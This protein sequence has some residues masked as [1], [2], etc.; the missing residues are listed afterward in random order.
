MKVR[1]MK[2]AVEF[3]RVDH[4]RLIVP[5]ARFLSFLPIKNQGSRQANS[6]W[7]VYQTW[8]QQDAVGSQTR[9][10]YGTLRSLDVWHVFSL[11]SAPVSVSDRLWRR[12]ALTAQLLPTFLQCFPLR[13]FLLS[14]SRV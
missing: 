8:P 2:S 10:G 11:W 9:A 1:G 14:S 7:K 12:A 3:N 6:L 4:H 13:V 5:P